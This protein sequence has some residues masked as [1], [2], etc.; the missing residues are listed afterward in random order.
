MVFISES[1]INSPIIVSPPPASLPRQRCI[2]FSTMHC[3]TNGSTSALS[4]I[5]VSSTRARQVT[6]IRKL[7]E[8]RCNNVFH[9]QPTEG[10]CLLLAP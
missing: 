8:G 3:A 7:A 10:H 1:T 2:L 4:K 5:I 9:V 6:G